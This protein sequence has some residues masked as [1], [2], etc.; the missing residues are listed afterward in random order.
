MFLESF[1]QN[2]ER[3]RER[4]RSELKEYRDISNKKKTRE[5][6]YEKRKT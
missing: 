5:K 3:E 4:E 1:E 6:F 2:Y